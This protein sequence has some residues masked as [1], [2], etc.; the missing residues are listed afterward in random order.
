MAQRKQF[1]ELD[2]SN[3]FLF[4]AALE[5]EETSRLVL[6][7]ILG[8]QVGKIKVKAERSILFNSDFR[9]VRLDVYARDDLDVEYNLEMQNEDQKN[10][11][12]RSRY[13]QAE[14]DVASLKP[15]ENFQD[16][17]TC[18]IIFICSFDPFGKKMYRYTFE[19]RCVEE[20]F[21]LDD[22]V[23]RIFLSTQGEN[24]K[25]VPK[26]LVH[27][28]KYVKNSSDSYVEQANDSMISQLH[29]RVKALKESRILEERYMQFEEMLK[30]EHSIGK[31]EGTW[32]MWELISHMITDGR[33]DL[34][35]KLR[36]DEAFYQEMLKEYHL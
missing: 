15:G 34:I 4:A 22:G 2:L 24:E 3:A 14:M 27:F 31:Q 33:T 26:E 11:A 28:L 17:K 5:D 23:K 21:P 7:C 6:S 30:R 20:D 13:H 36:E 35:P 32:Q 9:S 12:K 25:D 1:K 18:Y 19:N 16:L 8:Y 10:L 29:G